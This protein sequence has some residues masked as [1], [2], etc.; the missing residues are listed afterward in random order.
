M[1]ALVACETI[2]LALLVL[3]VAALLRSHAELLRRLG[4][5]EGG[6]E[7][8][9]LGPLP[10]PA[11]APAVAAAEIA[12]TTLDGDALKLSL[13]PGSPPTLVAFLTSGCSTCLTFWE[14]LRQ[15]TPVD[16]PR[17]GSR[18]VVVT[19]DA[20]DESSSRLGALRPDGVPVVMSSEAWKR[21]RVPG[22]PYFLY[23]EDGVVAG[24]G[25]ASTWKQVESLLRDA[26]YDAD[27]HGNGGNGDRRTDSIDETLR[28]AGIVPG[29]PSLYPAGE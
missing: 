21:L 24:E 1:T 13:G 4:P 29:H 17:P 25:S 2:L 9:D 7:R 26:V 22:S 20:R 5:P 16:L 14:D 3:L 19:K 8:R 28:A 12:G 10:E 11:A 6:D 27:R 23:V 18:L 15:G